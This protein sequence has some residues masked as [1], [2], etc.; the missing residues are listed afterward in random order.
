MLITN[1]F[2]ISKL[3][4]VTLPDPSNK[5]AISVCDG[6]G[7][8]KNKEYMKEKKMIRTKNTVKHTRVR[9]L[10]SF[11]STYKVPLKVLGMGADG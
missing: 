11:S 4:G 3:S 10:I 7:H 8:S 6:R 9:M 5:K 1:F 2:I